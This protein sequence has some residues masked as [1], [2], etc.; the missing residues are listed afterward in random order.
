VPYAVLGLSPKEVVFQAWLNEHHAARGLKID[1]NPLD[2]WQVEYLE[3]LREQADRLRAA[4]PM[5]EHAFRTSPVIAQESAQ[6]VDHMPELLTVREA[7]KDGFGGRWYTGHGVR[8]WP[9]G[10]LPRPDFS[11]H[12]SLA[13]HRIPASRGRV[14]PR[15]EPSRHRRA[16]RGSAGLPG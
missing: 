6:S 13:A 12:R 7:S 5:S 4:Y 16:A 11:S 8:T 15:C 3:A 1:G 14:Q 9:S 10:L 2:P